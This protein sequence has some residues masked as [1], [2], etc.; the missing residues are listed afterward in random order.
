MKGGEGKMYII[1]KYIDLISNKVSTIIKT[2]RYNEVKKI[3]DTYNSM[4]YEYNQYS[5]EMKNISQDDE[6]LFCEKKAQLLIKEIDIMEYQ[7]KLLKKYEYILSKK[8]GEV[9]D[10]FWYKVD[11][12][13][14]KM[15]P[16]VGL[17]ISDIYNIKN[18]LPIERDLRSIYEI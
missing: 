11:L 18:M 3:V 17:I 1:E 12:K 15:D 9:Y 5:D 6:K 8:T 16:K 7:R 4:I 10:E 2:Y 14:E 13:K